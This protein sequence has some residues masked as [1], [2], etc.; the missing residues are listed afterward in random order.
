MLSL[1][2]A[3]EHQYRFD[4]AQLDRD[5]ALRRSIREREASRAELAREALPTPAPRTVR[6]GH[7]MGLPQP[8]AA[9]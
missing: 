4:S 1:V 8:A 2:T 5:V 3:A 6:R 7:R 9:C